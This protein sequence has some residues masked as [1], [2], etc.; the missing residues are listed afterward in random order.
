MKFENKIKKKELIKIK[1]VPGIVNL[2]NTA[3][4]SFSK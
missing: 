1:I 3:I 4:N 2:P